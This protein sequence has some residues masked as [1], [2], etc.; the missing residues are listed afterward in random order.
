LLLAEIAGGNDATTFG[1]HVSAPLSQ[2]QTGW[3]AFPSHRVSHFL[4]LAISRAEVLDAVLSEGLSDDVD[5]IV[6]ASA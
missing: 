2:P 4:L 5:G 3:L 1:V 6:A